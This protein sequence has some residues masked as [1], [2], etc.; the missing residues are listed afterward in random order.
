MGIICK[1][2]EMHR[3][4]RRQVVNSNRQMD[5]EYIN[6]KE[7]QEIYESLLKRKKV[8]EDIYGTKLNTQNNDNERPI[9]IN[10]YKLMIDRLVREVEELEKRSN[11]LKN[12]KK[13]AQIYFHFS[14][15][16][17]Y[18]INVDIRTKLDDAFKQAIFNTVNEDRE[19]KCTDNYFMGIENINYEQIIFLS[20][21]KNVSEK[22][23][24][25][26]PVS[27]LV[28][29]S[30]SSISIIVLIEQIL[31]KTYYKV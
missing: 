30:N 29:D 28:N 8:L 27:S 21:G 15:G 5:N 14:T 1:N 7:I 19:T 13:N 4:I 11:L 23:I 22:F 31:S 2:E 12:Q 17:L 26:E 20:G 18:K 24:N 10:D 3:R 9:S 25:N 16:Q 6:V